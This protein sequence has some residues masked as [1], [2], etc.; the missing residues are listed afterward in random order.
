VDDLSYSD[1]LSS[2]YGL[3]KFRYDDGSDR[4]IGILSSRAR[5]HLSEYSL[6]E[7]SQL[8]SSLSRVGV[9]NKPLLH[10]VVDRLLVSP[11]LRT[12]SVQ[13]ISNMM[14]GI[15]R[16]GV[17]YPHKDELWDILADALADQAAA[18]PDSLHDSIA[19]LLA[20]SYAN[21]RT[22]P[23]SQLFSSIS[24][25]LIE[26]SS[27]DL[28]DIMKYIRACSRVQFRSASALQACAE[29][30]RKKFS[31]E[32]LAMDTRDLLSLYTDL[33]KLGAEMTEVSEELRLRGVTVSDRTGQTW[34]KKTPHLPRSGKAVR[35]PPV[36]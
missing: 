33:D 16:C 36:W 34:F 14:T 17:S 4:C 29:N 8:L 15:A 10:S 13:C 11:E 21:P 5:R 25:I 7:C 18:S 20:Y 9:K 23:N 30:M 27:I 31:P 1:V 26:A 19:G 35:K 22:D 2:I 24:D 28:A 12:M 32:L 3:S 6:A